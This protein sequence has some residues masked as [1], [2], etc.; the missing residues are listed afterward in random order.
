MWN[1][2]KFRFIDFILNDIYYNKKCKNDRQDI[3]SKCNELISKY[4]S[5]D[6]IVY[7]QIKM[8]NLL[9][10]YRWNNQELNNIYNNELIS[11]LKNIISIYDDDLII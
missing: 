1:L 2:P 11:Q 8:E 6:I 5:L 3:I 7:S 9:K 10:D 4:F